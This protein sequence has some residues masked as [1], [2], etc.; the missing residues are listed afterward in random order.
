MKWF[1]AVLRPIGALF[2]REPWWAEFWSGVT[3]ATWAAMSYASPGALGGWPSMRVLTEIASDWSWHLAGIGLGA[4]QV[5]FLLCDLRW[6]RW[7]A[8]LL[9]CWFWAVLTLGVWEAVPWA[10]GVAVYGGW[11]AVN[12][13][14][15][16]RLLR[17]AGLHGR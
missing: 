2:Q 13:F 8:A 4:A 1:D 11:C 16:V 14:S 15:I 17:R 6:L 10:P 3:A 12:V 5:L 7:G 9:L